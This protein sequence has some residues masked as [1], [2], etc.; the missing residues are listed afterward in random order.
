MFAALRPHL[1]RINGQQ[2]LLLS[3]D[4]QSLKSAS[5]QSTKKLLRIIDGMKNA[6][7][8]LD[9]FELRGGQI[10]GGE[11]LE[12]FGGQVLLSVALIVAPRTTILVLFIFLEHDVL[13][14]VLAMGTDVY[15]VS[16]W[17]VWFFAPNVLV[18]CTSSN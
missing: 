1:G 9:F 13:Q 15:S 8:P 16:V 11:L 6:S 17:F 5:E 3:N 7:S 4:S 14:P 10:G 12:S 18:S 2:L